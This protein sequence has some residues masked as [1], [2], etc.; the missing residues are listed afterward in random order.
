VAFIYT[1][2]I[3]ALFTFDMQSILKEYV[4]PSYENC[5]PKR[6]ISMAEEIKE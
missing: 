5:D 4:D 1:L 6:E 3:Q 2:L